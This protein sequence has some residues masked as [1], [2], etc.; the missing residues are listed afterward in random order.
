MKTNIMLK[1]RKGIS[2]ILATLLL[3]VIAVAAIVVT[4][5]W[6]M[7][8]MRSSGHQAGARIKF[9]SVIIDST[10]DNITIYVR[11]WGTEDVYVDKVYINGYD[12]TVATT[13]SG[14]AKLIPAGET[15]TITGT[16]RV[17]DFEQGKTYKVK[18]AGPETSYEDSVVAQ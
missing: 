4:Y 18:V 13:L 10:N 8:Y 16:T 12:V 17:Y 15:L 14:G 9:D 11:N 2:P 6:I 5:A 3:I 7:V 1:S